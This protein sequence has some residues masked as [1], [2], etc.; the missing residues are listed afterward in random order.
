MDEWLPLTFIFL[1]ENSVQRIEV[2]HNQRNNEALD[3]YQ[4]DVIVFLLCDGLSL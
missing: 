4:N 1:L 3:K 2:D